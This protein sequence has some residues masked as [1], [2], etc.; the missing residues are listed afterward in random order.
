R[1][2]LLGAVAARHAIRHL[3]RGVRRRRYDLGR[4]VVGPD[5]RRLAAAGRTDIG[6]VGERRAGADNG[7]REDRR[8]RHQAAALLL[9]LI[10]A[11]IGLGIVAL[12]RV[13]IVW[14][15]GIA[16]IVLLARLEPPVE[17]IVVARRIRLLL[18]V[19]LLIGLLVVA[20][21]GLLVGMILV[22]LALI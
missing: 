8:D 21:T 20:L 7:K 4:R 11:E 1:H 3:G 9:R 10:V 14:I 12:E 16:L 17:R 5:D 18:R 22:G 13:G 6:L 15:S 2:D 19:R